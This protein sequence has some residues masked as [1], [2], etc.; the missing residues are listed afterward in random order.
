MKTNQPVL[1]PNQFLFAE[2]L[3]GFLIYVLVLGLVDDYTD[4]VSAKS[5]STIILASLVLEALTFLTFRLKD[6]WIGW[7]SDRRDGLSRW[8]TLL[9]IWPIMFFSKFV[10]LW[11]LDVVLGNDFN[12]SG[13]L[14]ILIVIACVTVLARLANALFVRLGAPADILG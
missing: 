8:Q 7:L 12:V 9:A 6:W 4:W 3:I 5:F 1:S 10:F 2:L 14:A 13:F 11:A